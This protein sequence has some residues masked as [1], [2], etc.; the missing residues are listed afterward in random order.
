MGGQNPGTGVGASLKLRTAEQVQ[1]L[2]ESDEGLQVN[3]GEGVGRVQR[4]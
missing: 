4:C 1:A 3:V 2:F